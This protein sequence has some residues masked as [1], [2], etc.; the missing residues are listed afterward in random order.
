MQRPQMRC[1]LSLLAAAMVLGAAAPTWAQTQK[2]VLVIYSTRRDTQIAIKGDQ[3]IPELLERGLREKPDY[4]SEYID[5][6]RFPEAQYAEAFRDYL[7]LKYQLA[8]FDLIIA[9]QRLAFQ[10]VST[11]RDELF[12]G[13][14][15]V[16]LNDSPL[17]PRPPNSTG[18][19]VE[20]DYRRTIVLAQKLQPDLKNVFFVVG[21]SA[22]DKVME[23]AVRAQMNA[24]PTDLTLTY[25]TDMT[26]DE[27][28]GR[29]TALPAR[30]MVYY[31][32]VYQDGAGVNLNPMDYLGRLAAMATQ[33]TYSWVDSAIGSGIVGGSLLT[34]EAEL[35]GLAATAL[36][37]LRGERADS[38]PLA[39][40]D[41]QED[42]VDWRQIQRWE[43]DETRI[44]AAAIVMYRQP[45]ALERYRWFIV[46]AVALMLAQTA[47]IA[48]LLIERTKRRRAEQGARESREELS[49]SY[50]RIRDMGGRL[51]AAQET[52]RARIAR[53][54]H[55]D[56]SQQMTLLSIDLE[57]LGDVSRQ[58]MDQ[59]RK[60]A[61][62]AL[63]RSREI[64]KGVHDISHRLHPAKLRLI[65]LVGALNGLARELSSANLTIIF[66]HD[67]VPEIIAHDLALC[68]YRIAQE[69]VQNAIRHGHARR[70]KV[71]LTERVGQLTLTVI[72]D[73]VGFDVDA[74]CNKGL[75]LISM[76]ERLE[77]FGGT[78]SI[79]STPGGGASVEAV[80]PSLV[81]PLV[82]A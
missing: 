4:Y 56:I 54:L 39:T 70:I 11:Y 72:D 62:E 17:A 10:F 49:A 41:V 67:N 14:P 28:E 27:I 48:G 19:I 77:P 23:R 44:P 5:G 20:P 55:D 24:F 79:H 33:P 76:R 82:P 21:S 37:V 64:T 42:R 61:H 16:F 22:R 65:G 53:E 46:G 30:S 52:E 73:G 18:V 47:L 7:R 81:P 59:A 12:P 34:V 58:R 63:L 1:V 78:L 29:V 3:Q 75:G 45:S 32:L 51:L 66:T 74:V 38:I 50:E 60:L 13:A 36:R 9:V 8:D 43:I 31:L 25:L 2:S 69:A 40:L 68:L 35:R 15:I 80:V 71:N 26:T 6:A 57:L